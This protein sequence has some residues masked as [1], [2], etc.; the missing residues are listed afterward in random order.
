V[1][2]RT[3][4]VR[5][6]SRRA[7]SVGGPCADESF[8]LNEPD[9]VDLG[10]QAQRAIDA[11]AEAEDYRWFDPDTDFAFILADNSTVALDAQGMAAVFE[12]GM[13]FK[14]ALTFAARGK[15]DWLE[16]EGRTRAEL[17]AFDVAAEWPT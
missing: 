9:Q 16:S 3:A 7:Y 17:L 5:S 11:G 4:R 1:G 2:R 12:A 10:Q 15:K 14:S 6:R 8:G 13:A